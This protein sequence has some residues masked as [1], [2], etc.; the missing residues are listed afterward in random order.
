MIHIIFVSVTLPNSK[1]IR[2]NN[3]GRTY[4]GNSL[5]QL[6]GLTNY[7]EFEN[8]IIKTYV[9]TKDMSLSTPKTWEHTG[10]NSNEVYSTSIPIVDTIAFDKIRNI[11]VRCNRLGISGSQ[12]SNSGSSVT[13]QC[14]PTFAFPSTVKNGGINTVSAAAITTESYAQD[15]NTSE[16]TSF[17]AFGFYNYPYI[18]TWCEASYNGIYA[19]Y[20]TQSSI[21]TISLQLVGWYKNPWSI[22]GVLTVTA[23]ITI[24]VTYVA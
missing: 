6:V 22:Y 17:N 19:Q 13:V 8:S 10:Y 9:Q 21:P 1:I 14:T 12:V 20:Q 23:N 7:D 5:N 24:Y 18:Y 11:T 16:N 3:D 15:F 2:W 4:I